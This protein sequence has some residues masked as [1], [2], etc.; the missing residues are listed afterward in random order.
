MSVCLVESQ[1]QSNHNP[2]NLMNQSIQVHVQLPNWMN[3][4]GELSRPS[5]KCLLNFQLMNWTSWVG[6]DCGW[7]QPHPLG[8]YC[9]PQHQSHLHYHP[10]QTA[11]MYRLSVD[12]AHES[13][14][15]QPPCQREREIERDVCVCVYFMTK[16]L[17]VLY[18]VV[19]VCSTIVNRAQ[20]PLHNLTINSNQLY[21]SLWTVCTRH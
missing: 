18:T 1:E 19:L 16:K 10:E 17:V 15:H 11:E 7:S 21:I 4:L 13:G 20:W 2:L 5:Q 3:W 12:A 14:A 6:P 8:C 9:N